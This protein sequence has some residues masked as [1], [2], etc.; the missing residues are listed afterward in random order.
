M[1]K[2]TILFIA[3][4]VMFCVSCASDSEHRKASKNASSPV[5]QPLSLTEL[6]KKDTVVAAMIVHERDSCSSPSVAYILLASGKVLCFDKAVTTAPFT[7]D[8]AKILFE[9]LISN[10]FT[11][12]Q[13]IPS[14]AEK[15]GSV[16]ATLTA[17]GSNSSS[18]AVPCLDYTLFD[19]GKVMCFYKTA[20]TIPF[21]LEEAKILLEAKTQGKIFI[22]SA[23]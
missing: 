18:S 17:R 5:S 4:I 15:C 19:D 13:K 3:C 6:V 10:K 16:V 23:E 11:N 21:T 8:I 1:K 2:F 7:L 22:N 9:V 14:N 12:T 20:A